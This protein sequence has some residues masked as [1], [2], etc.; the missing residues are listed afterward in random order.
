VCLDF[1]SLRSVF[2]MLFHNA[3]IASGDPMYHVK[4]KIVRTINRIL[5]IRLSS[6]PYISGDTFRQ[7]A[8]IKIDS[9]HD[10]LTFESNWN[11]TII[12]CATD[13]LDVFIEWALPKIESKFIL[14]TH[15]SDYS[16]DD[17]Y[18]ALLNHELL[19]HWF[20]QNNTISHKKITAVPIGL[21]NRFHYNNGRLSRFKSRVGFEQGHNGKI[22]CSF[23]VNTNP[24][25]REVALRI[26]E[27]SSFTDV[28]RVNARTYLRLLSDYAFVASPAG[29]GIDCHRTWEALYLGVIPIVQGQ[30]FY[31]QFPGFPGLVLNQWEDLLKYDKNS[32]SREHMI[33]RQKLQNADFIWAPY[34]YTKV[35]NMREILLKD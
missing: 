33:C 8:D 20:A 2:L 32:L 16:V 29:N 5:N 18:S 25:V 15:N 34:W 35:K 27:P 19:F 1:S 3:Y 9:A 6:Y 21:E 24:S 14:I 4:N 7:F 13:V 31:S 26:L 17:K 30:D 10:L 23:S 22:L 11:R 28:A 12:F